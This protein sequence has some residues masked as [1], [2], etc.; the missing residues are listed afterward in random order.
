MGGQAGFSR[1]LL[2]YTS[3]SDTVMAGMNVHPT[4][5]FELGLGLTWSVSDASLAPFEL[6]ADDYV[7]IT[8]PMVYD[9]STTHTNSDL[10]LERTEAEVHA[11]YNFSNSF[12]L[13]LN[14]LY[15]DYQDDAPYLHDLTGSLDLITAAVGW[16]F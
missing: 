5:K 2:D 4:E 9:F 12:W 3:T 16:A 7:A 10:D 13:R 6:P 14:Y 1:N 15:I 11:K 8:P